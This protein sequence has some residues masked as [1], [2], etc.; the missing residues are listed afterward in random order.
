MYRTLKRGRYGFERKITF[1]SAPT[2]GVSFLLTS[3]RY[4][5]LFLCNSS[6]GIFTFNS[7]YYIMHIN[8][9]RDEVF[10]DPRAKYSNMIQIKEIQIL[11]VRGVCA[12]VC[13]CLCIRVGIYF[14]SSEEILLQVKIE[15]STYSHWYNHH[16]HKSKPNYSPFIRMM[17][18]KS[19]HILHSD[20]SAKIS[21]VF[22][23][24]SRYEKCNII[25]KMGNHRGFLLTFVCEG[26]GQDGSKHWLER[27][28][29]VETTEAEWMWIWSTTLWNHQFL[30]TLMDFSWANIEQLL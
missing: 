17:L 10:V 8:V 22:Y 9:P 4:Q 15:T 18:T 6:T 19:I 2:R 13:M 7:L 3:L 24:A 5:C 25:L 20:I 29:Y 28:E 14:N 12:C 27:T 1:L 21:Q 30:V 16:P 26:S 23:S 11:W